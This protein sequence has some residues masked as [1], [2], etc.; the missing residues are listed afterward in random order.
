MWDEDIHNHN[1]TEMI[2]RVDGTCSNM[3]EGYVISQNCCILAI[4]VSYNVVS[5][6]SRSRIIS[7]H[8]LGFSFGAGDRRRVG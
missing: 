1:K 5:E 2:Y 7:W 4:H 3:K 8:L 6:L